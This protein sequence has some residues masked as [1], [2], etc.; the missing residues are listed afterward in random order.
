MNDSSS[1]NA[2]SNSDLSQ[3]GFLER[4]L[5]DM[6]SSQV[7][8][9][10]MDDILRDNLQVIRAVGNERLLKATSQGEFQLDKNEGTISTWVN[11]PNG[12]QIFKLDY[13]SA[14][15]TLDQ[16][17]NLIKSA[18]K[19]ISSLMEMVGAAGGGAG[20]G[21]GDKISS[22]AGLS[23]PP[24]SD[25]SSDPTKPMVGSP[26]K[27]G[28]DFA[29]VGDWLSS[30]FS[31]LIAVMVKAMITQ[32]KG[33][34]LESQLVQKEREQQVA[35]AQTE[36]SLTQQS[37]EFE[38][39]NLESQASVDY[40]TASTAAA[41]A[42]IA[43][44]GSVASARSQ[45]QAESEFDNEQSTRQTNLAKMNQAP[46]EDPSFKVAFDGKNAKAKLAEIDTETA[47]ASRDDIAVQMKKYKYVDDGSGNK[48]PVITGYD[49][50]DNEPLYALSDEY[51]A[52]QGRAALV[53]NDN[54]ADIDT[55]AAAYKQHIDDKE[56]LQKDYDYN[57][58]N[59]T[60]L[61]NDRTEILRQQKASK[62]RILDQTA[63]ATQSLAKAG[64]E[65]LQAGY[66]RA[67]GSVD[68]LNR[69]TQNA[70]QITGTLVQTAEQRR[71]AYGQYIISLAQA[72]IQ[73]I[74]QNSQSFRQGRG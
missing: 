67:K 16:A 64:Q 74:A 39:K 13:K 60:K 55:K 19:S 25:V 12:V 6:V 49:P 26:A 17:Q 59:R 27:G 63:Q 40:T 42:G 68:A 22:L 53:E 62:Y 70:G 4:E 5:Q 7:Q 34:W 47:A 73:M 3:K 57:K 69:N 43:F 11:T 54:Q 20:V 28:T 46:E 50:N 44:A 35:I 24:P 29:N 66:I 38:A 23:G 1:F 48:E 41:Q 33:Q 9:R 52:L 2:N 56:K 21:L 71:E 72:I 36:A 58:D 37:A 15:L 32:S 51:K 14:G 65:M 30:N 10:S 31:T 18:E 8:N 61:I 45:G